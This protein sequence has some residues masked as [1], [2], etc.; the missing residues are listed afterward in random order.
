M[1]DLELSAHKHK[2]LS[3]EVLAQGQDSPTSGGTNHDWLA[4][5]RCYNTENR[6][7]MDQLHLQRGMEKG[8]ERKQQ[9]CC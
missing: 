4:E 1:V 3:G 6:V 8:R 2:E 9:T 5:G 7:N